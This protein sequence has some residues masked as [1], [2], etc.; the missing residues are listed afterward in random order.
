MGAEFSPAVGT[1]VYSGS[2][3]YLG[4]IAQCTEGELL[5]RMPWGASYWLS[6]TLVHEQDDRHVTL[7]ISDQTLEWWRT[8]PPRTATTH[9]PAR[10]L[11]N[12]RQYLQADEFVSVLASHIPV[13]GEHRT[14]G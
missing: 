9:G 5:V 12:L 4:V 14:T 10:P 6:A 2:G 3:R 13:D 8:H 7:Q 1:A 11:P